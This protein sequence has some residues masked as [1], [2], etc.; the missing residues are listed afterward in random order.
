MFLPTRMRQNCK[1]TLKSRNSSRRCPLLADRCIDGDSSDSYV[2][3]TNILKVNFSLQ[4]LDWP[5]VSMKYVTES[6]PE[7]INEAEYNETAKA[8]QRELEIR[9][10]YELVFEYTSLYLSHRSHVKF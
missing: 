2:L 3:N 8:V 9:G 6:V 7:V 4:E 10:D 5:L 1:S